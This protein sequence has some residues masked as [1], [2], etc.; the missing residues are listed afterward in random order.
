MYNIGD[1]Y[2]YVKLFCKYQ[3]I[4]VVNKQH[5][6]AYVGVLF[7]ELKQIIYVHAYVIII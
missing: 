1:E 2:S 3:N 7:Y 4:F 5:E 6:F